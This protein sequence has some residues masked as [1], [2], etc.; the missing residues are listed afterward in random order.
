MSASNNVSTTWTP[1]TEPEAA[2]VLAESVPLMHSHGHMST[3]IEV[4]EEPSSPVP[5]DAH[6]GDTDSFNDD[7]STLKAVDKGK[8]RASTS[9]SDKDKTPFFIFDPT[10]G[11]SEQA[12]IEAIKAFP[13]LCTDGVS[14]LRVCIEY[15]NIDDP[16]IVDAAYGLPPPPESVIVLAGIV[17]D[18]GCQVIKGGAILR[19]HAQIVT[20]AASRPNIVFAIVLITLWVNNPD[21]SGAPNG[22]TLGWM[23]WTVRRTLN[24]PLDVSSTVPITEISVP[25]ILAEFG[26]QFV[27]ISEN[28]ESTLEATT[29][30]GTAVGSNSGTS[31]GSQGGPS[32]AT[33]TPTVA[34]GLWRRR[35][36]DVMKESTSKK[37]ILIEGLEKQASQTVGTERNTLQYLRDQCKDAIATLGVRGRVF[38]GS[39]FTSGRTS[40]RTSGFASSGLSSP[41]EGSISTTPAITSSTFGGGLSLLPAPFRM[42][43][44]IP[45]TTQITGTHLVAS[46]TPVGS[47][48]IINTE[49][50]GG[51][52]P[53][54]RSHGTGNNPRVSQNANVV[55]N[56]Q[57]H[58]VVAHHAQVFTRQA[59][60]VAHSASAHIGDCSTISNMFPST[61][62]PSNIGGQ[63]NSSGN[64]TAN[65][66]VVPA[67]FRAFVVPTDVANDELLQPEA[68]EDLIRTN[69][70]RNT[71][72]RI[73]TGLSY[74]LA[75][76][77]GDLLGEDALTEL[78]SERSSVWD[79]LLTGV[80]YQAT[81]TRSQRFDP[82]AAPAASRPTL[83]HRC[84]DSKNNDEREDE[85]EE[86]QPAPAG[87]A[88]DSSRRETIRRQ[89]IESERRRR[90]EL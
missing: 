72:A 6:E 42:S 78:G 87:G 19:K 60:V 77:I 79:S 13:V 55:G 17:I 62:G 32:N 29:S 49:E 22:A 59:N 81:V 85:D 45:T 52:R 12:S 70:P 4:E 58:V 86:F 33:T 18:T 36:R 69:L 56:A 44:S 63:A 41:V 20:A 82:I 50:A 40:G 21:Y 73:V 65:T 5:Q 38:G 66:I 61:A 1:P 67:G 89:R 7:R 26:L 31:G 83:G 64:A 88:T 48:T 43:P 11:L 25:A 23:A 51:S 24:L 71:K 2:G 3:V 14:G 80:P 53:V 84:R 90:D 8:R 16:L 57:T 28:L 76:K 68:W 46:N 15:A 9:S 27:V 39:G 47:T 54:A 75:N 35:K 30:G 37:S 34:G 74:V 10:F